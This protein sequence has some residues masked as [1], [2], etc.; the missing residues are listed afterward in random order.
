M[1]GTRCRNV[2]Q[3]GE[4]QTGTARDSA[5]ADGTIYEMEQ[6]GDFP[7]RFALSPKWCCWDLTEVEAWLA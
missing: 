5:S 2:D 3:A 4:P 1:H 7:R 6:R